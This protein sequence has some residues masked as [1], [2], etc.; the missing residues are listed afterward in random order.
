LVVLPGGG[1]IEIR[2][3]VITMDEGEDLAAVLLTDPRGEMMMAPAGP[4]NWPSPKVTFE[5]VFVRGRG[6]LVAVKQSRPFELDVKNALVALDGTLID[7]DPSTADP[8][9]F[10]SGAVV[11]LNRVTTYLGGSLVHFRAAERKTEMAPAGLARTD[12]IANN[13]VFAPAGS[14]ADPLVRADRLDSKEQVE[15]WFGWKGRDNVY[16]YDKKNVVLEIRPA[17]LEAMPIKPIDG[18]RWLEMTQEEGDPFASVRFSYGEGLP[19][20]GQGRKFLVVRPID[21]GPARSDPPR[22]EG[23][24]DVGAPTDVPVPFADE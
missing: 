2:N 14:S 15:K 3:S 24:P 7:I 18:D 16:G 19:Q 9:A 23:S 12:V 13:C 20:A 6:R 21:F 4:A 22:P 8:S 17:D 10:G 1:Q 5:N 11:Q